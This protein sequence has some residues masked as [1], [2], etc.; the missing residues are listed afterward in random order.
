M[1]TQMN[2]DKLITLKEAADMIGVHRDTLR[3]WDR[4][5]DCPLV[6]V[7]TEG[8][9]RRYRLSDIKRYQGL[10]EDDETEEQ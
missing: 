9:H 7:R 10:K 8:N 2:T 1:K 5:P 3:K 4:K 6:P